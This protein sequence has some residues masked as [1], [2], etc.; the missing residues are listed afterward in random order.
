ITAADG[1][2]VAF[3]DG[4]GEPVHVRIKS[5]RAER[6]LIRDPQLA[7]AEIYMD[8]DLE[9]VEGDVLGLLRILY[10]A[11]NDGK[12]AFGGVLCWIEGLR[13]LTRRL[14][15]LNT[16]GRARDNVRRHYDLSGEH[17]RLF[18]DPDMQ[19]SC[20]YFEHPGM[21]LEDAQLA[22]KRHIAAK[23]MPRPGQRILDI[24]SGWG[25]LGLYLARNFDAEVTG[26]TL[27]DA[28]H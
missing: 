21:S 7:L 4:T 22:K 11:S 17:Y 20:A 8:G 25:G 6:A 13:Y 1:R 14:Q 28:Q 15:Q 23:L 27:S 16:L 19:Y 10:S 24:G 2:T 5:R 26:V 12:D 9:F 3:G 18:L